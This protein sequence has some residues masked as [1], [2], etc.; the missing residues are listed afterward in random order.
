MFPIPQ[1]TLLPGLYADATIQLEHKQDALAVPLQAVDHNGERTLVDVVDA[2]N[3]I[4]ARQVVL[5]IQTPTDAEVIS[6]L[7]E[8]DLVVVSDRSSLKAGQT[9]Q[10]KA[11]D[12]MQYQG[13]DQH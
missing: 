12:L 6:G 1:H 5:G 2:S 13:S 8:G 11:V 7:N 9:V 10:P 3:R 4:E